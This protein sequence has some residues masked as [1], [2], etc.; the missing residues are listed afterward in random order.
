MSLCS[1][2]VFHIKSQFNFSPF[3][4][5]LKTV[6]VSVFVTQQFQVHLMN[7][8]QVWS[9]AELPLCRESNT[10]AAAH[11]LLEF[12]GAGSVLYF[13]FFSSANRFVAVCYCP[14]LEGLHWPDWKPIW[15]GS[16]WHP[17]G[18]C[19]EGLVASP[20]NEGQLG[21]HR[22]PMR[23]R[24][25]CVHCVRWD[26]RWR[27]F[28]SIHRCIPGR[29]GDCK[30]VYYIFLCHRCHLKGFKCITQLVSTHRPISLLRCL[31]RPH[32]HLLHQG[33][34]SLL[35]ELPVS[36]LS[37][38]TVF[39][40]THVCSWEAVPSRPWFHYLDLRNC[41]GVAAVVVYFFK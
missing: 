5:R 36:P 34:S 2:V 7:V 32:S 41:Y 1:G 16:Q 13:Y 18:P 12:G 26:S 21:L 9:L 38:V 17:R 24:C 37:L 28:S 35:S 39:S 15:T 33:F 20:V 23:G 40:D 25:L 10:I 22:K 19:G 4:S 6:P 8:L 3:P 29:E 31:G 11:A 27:I 14:T 30:P